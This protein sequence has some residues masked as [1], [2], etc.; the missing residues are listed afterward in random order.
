MGLLQYEY[1]LPTVNVLWFAVCVLCEAVCH[2]IANNKHF[3]CHV[4]TYTVWCKTLN[5]KILANGLI[6]KF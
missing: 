4:H 6:V 5:R 3:I 1:C 2:S